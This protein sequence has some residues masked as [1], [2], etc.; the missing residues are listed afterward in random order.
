LNQTTSAGKV[1][2]VGSQVERF[3]GTLNVGKVAA[4][5]SITDA[6]VDIDVD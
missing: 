2:A 5:E 1:P 6:P 4:L 3:V